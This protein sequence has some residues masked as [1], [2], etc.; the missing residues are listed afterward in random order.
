MVRVASSCR[1]RPSRKAASSVAPISR[2]EMDIGRQQR[3]ETTVG[4]SEGSDL[5]EGL[6]NLVATFALAPCAPFFKLLRH[7][8]TDRRYHIGRIV[9]R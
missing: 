8:L 9:S 3:S 2:T 7:T 5:R 1:L 4:L 6:I